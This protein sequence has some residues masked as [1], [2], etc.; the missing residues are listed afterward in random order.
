MANTELQELREQTEDIVTELKA[1]ADKWETDG[2]SATQEEMTRYDELEEKR[3]EL[4][5]QIG[6]IERASKVRALIEPNKSE[7]F[8]APT[9]KIKRKANHADYNSAFKAWALSGADTKKRVRDEWKRSADLLDVDY[10]S[11]D[12]VCRDQSSDT[13]GE[14]DDFIN[15]S[16]FKGHVEA[17]K[18]FGGMLEA[19]NVVNVATAETSHYAIDDDTSA[20]AA[21]HAQNVAVTNVGVTVD[22]VSVTP[23]IYSSGVFPVSLQLIRDSRS[24]VG[25]WVSRKLSRRLLSKINTDLTTALYT[26]T[27]SGT[28]GLSA[29]TDFDLRTDADLYDL[30]FSVDP[31]YRN[32]PR[33][34]WM[35][36][37]NELNKLVVSL[38]DT[39]GQPIWGRGLRDSP[40]GVLLA[41]RIIINQDC[42]TP[43]AGVEKDPIVF[44]DFENMIVHTV[45][46][47]PT[48]RRLDE[49]YMNQLAI[50]FVAHWEVGGAVVDAGQAPLKTLTT[51][52]ISGDT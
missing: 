3:T 5:N 34:Y 44:G 50:G 46:A 30:Y 15:D 45:G 33:T 24:D 16:M 8:G 37:D 27:T 7:K 1:L 47:A 9:I 36:N 26:G 35:M 11:R 25:A 41:K 2:K 10:E 21:T 42:E 13:S 49:L 51:G 43:V 20:T 52:T 29:V 32:S 48:Y 12:W 14:G 40:E 22:R 19:S 18:A 4:T 31:S 17:R 23:S 6:T 38:Q 28:L 39:T